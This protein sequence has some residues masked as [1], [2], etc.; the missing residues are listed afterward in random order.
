MK[1]LNGYRMRLMLVGFVAAIALGVRSGN[2]EIIMSEPTNV[3]PVINNADD[4]QECDFSHDGLE[5]YFSAHRPGEYGKRDIYVSRRETI[6]DPW[7]EPV[8]LGPNVNSSG[9]EVEPSIS[10]DGLELYF[11]S[12]DNYNI[13]VCTRPSKDAPWSS[14][15]QVGPPVPS[16]DAWRT[17]ISADGLSLY[18]AAV[19]IGG[20]GGDDI[21]VTTRAT[22][23]DP[24]G[25]LVNLG[26]NV[27][28]SGDDFCPSISTDGLTLV[29]SRG[30]R[31]VW[32][33]TR[34]SINDDWG[35]AVDL[36]FPAPANICGP[37]L[38]PDGSTIYFDAHGDWGGYGNNDIW[39]IKFI[40]I[41]D[42]NSDGIV[43]ADDLCIMV[44]NWHTENTL[45]D[46][47]PLP[48]GDGFVDVLDLTV[49]AEH[50]FEEVGLVAHWKLDESEGDIAYNRISDN[51]GVLSGN[52]TWQPDNGHIAGAL[53]FDGADDYISTDFVL[54]PE[55][56]SFSIFAWI[57]GGA[58]GQVIVS[59]AD[60]LVGRS[61]K[62]GSTWLGIDSSNGTLMTGLMQPQSNLLAS[63]S[64]ISDDQWHHI[65]LVYNSAG[66]KRHL[67][68]DG[69]EVAVDTDYVT[70]TG[71]NAGL[72]IG[73]GQTLDP[74][75]FFSGL[76]DDVRIYNVALSEE[77]I[78]ALAE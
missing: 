2:A 34:K 26:P 28:S 70:N 40:P 73:V 6:N 33:T 32:A 66:W 45:C 30:Y 10:G 78:T 36:G 13:Y 47:A 15:V 29:F 38:S 35:P 43:D 41:V 25:E 21:W 17:D 24:W 7:Q 44:D 58:S 3:G 46:I 54:N 27:N 39:Q 50:L 20:Y 59:Q 5:L 72:Y 57:K 71:C 12:W 51:H 49:L 65:G 56:G 55:D 61:V 42:F 74:A 1:R 4:V 76:I 18:F 75:S 68:V 67:Y 60:A 22:K 52:P 23:H 31:S 16:N 69:I 48:L 9:S 64:L 11:G 14:R 63:E 62:S 53:Q 37:A 8:N 77:Q 19:G